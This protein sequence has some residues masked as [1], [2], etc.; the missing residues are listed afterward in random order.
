MTQAPKPIEYRKAVLDDETKIWPVVEEV[1]PEIPVLLDTPEDKAIMKGQ[2]VECRQSG[3]SWVAVDAS[4]TVVGFAL[5]RIDIHDQKAISLRYI[6]VSKNG[7]GRKVCATLMEKLKAD[8]APL[9]AGVLDDNRSAMA[10]RL[11]KMG[12]T[13][14]GRSG[15]ETKLR[16]EQKKK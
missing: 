12:F 15:N 11:V 8:G 4:G 2:I 16:W 3:K 14:T 9:T 13:K 6:G 1:A 5:A 7:R 10:D